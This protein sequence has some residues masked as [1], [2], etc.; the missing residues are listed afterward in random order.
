MRGRAALVAV[1]M[2]LGLTGCLFTGELPPLIPPEEPQ[3][4]RIVNE[5]PPRYSRV[6]ITEGG[7]LFEVWVTD[8]NSYDQDGLTVS[9]TLENLTGLRGEGAKLFL[10]ASDLPAPS[11]GRTSLILEAQVRDS[12]GLEGAEQISWELTPQAGADRVEDLE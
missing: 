7:Q 6:S 5:S 1:G 3:A 10:R 11:Q 4:P 8:A 9:W 12:T 2:V